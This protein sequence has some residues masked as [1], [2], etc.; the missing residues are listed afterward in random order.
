MRHA[1]PGQRLSHLGLDGSI[2]GTGTATEFS[3]S[4]SFGS[5]TTSP[6]LWDVSGLIRLHASNSASAGIVVL[7]SMLSL[8]PSASGNWRRKKVELESSAFISGAIQLKVASRDQCKK[9]PRPRQT[10]SS[11]FPFSCHTQKQHS[12]KLRWRQSIAPVSCKCTPIAFS[13]RRRLKGKRFMIIIFSR[14]R[15][16]Y[17]YFH[18]QIRQVFSPQYSWTPTSLPQSV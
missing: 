17:G 10:Q 14:C 13:G 5:G 6:E 8:C 3:T 12:R 18:S 16:I 2:L 15:T 4:A 1:R 9:R 11:S 7:G